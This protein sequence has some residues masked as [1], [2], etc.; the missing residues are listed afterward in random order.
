LGDRDAA[1]KRAD[2]RETDAA[3]HGEGAGGDSE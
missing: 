3:D 2:R 1:N